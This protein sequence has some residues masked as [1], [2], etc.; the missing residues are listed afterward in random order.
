[1]QLLQSTSRL[2]YRMARIL[3]STSGQTPRIRS[4]QCGSLYLY[5]RTTH[6][7]RKSHVL[8]FG[9]EDCHPM[10]WTGRRPVGA[11]EGYLLTSVRLRAREE[12]S[13]WLKWLLFDELLQNFKT[14]SLIWGPSVG[15]LFKDDRWAKLRPDDYLL[16]GFSQVK[17]QSLKSKLLSWKV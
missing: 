6:R 3:T 12:K 8:A 10:S 17:S 16:C 13:T 11:V 15:R 9:A 7:H 1:M 4:P 5:S 14:R 2:P